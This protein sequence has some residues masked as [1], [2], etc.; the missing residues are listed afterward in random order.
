MKCGDSNTSIQLWCIWMALPVVNW[1][2]WYRCFF[3]LLDTDA[4]EGCVR[5]NKLTSVMPEARQFG[6]YDST[7]NCLHIDALP[8]DFLRES[9]ILFVLNRTINLCLGV[10]GSPSN[11]RNFETLRPILRD[12]ILF[13]N[14]K[15]QNRTLFI[16]LIRLDTNSLCLCSIKW[17][18]L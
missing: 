10:L 3:L 5:Q 13:Y 7:D 1:T 12:H 16:N 15:I 14:Q 17:T 8:R 6:T 18:R 2:S 11:R 9:N 4:F